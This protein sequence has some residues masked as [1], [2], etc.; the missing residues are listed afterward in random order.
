M[1]NLSNKKLL[2]KIL[3]DFVFILFGCL[4]SSFAITSILKPNNLVTGG[5]TGIS[6]I[7]DS[8]TNINYTYI[9]YALSVLIL[10]NTFI[11]L[12]KK[13]AF[14][15]IF[16]SIFFPITL[17]IFDNLDISLIKNDL[18]LA[19]VFYGVIGGAGMGLIFKRG[20]SAG[21]TDTIAKIINKKIY[22][23]ISVSQILFVIDALIIISSAFIYNIN[24]ALYAILSNYIYI[25]SVNVILFGFGSK[26][27]KIEIISNE[28]EKISQ[29]IIDYLNI[30]VSIV[31]IYGGYTNTK[32]IKL[33]SICSPRDAML[34]KSYIAQIDLDAFVSIIS[35]DSVWGTAKDFE[36]IDTD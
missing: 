6:I 7:V 5:I 36:R 35:I 23:F 22:P 25:K 21:G 24:I 18:L 14:R 11:I 16:V 13:E 1:L 28:H 34:I 29:Y 26:K 31:N 12:G 3:I 4:L 8:L 2:N 27:Y 30:G 10:I 19:S 15:I 20:Y 33:V 32:K 9:Y 17:I